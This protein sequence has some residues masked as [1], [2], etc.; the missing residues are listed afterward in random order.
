MPGSLIL[1]TLPLIALAPSALFLLAFGCLSLSFIFALFE[2]AL[3]HYSSMKLMAEARE[4]G[5]EEQ[6]T[7]ALAD[8]D[9]LLLGSKIGRN[10]NG[11]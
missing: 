7:K 9:D 3:L 1:L 11:R 2:N 4:R 6:F 8:E 5:H 10:C